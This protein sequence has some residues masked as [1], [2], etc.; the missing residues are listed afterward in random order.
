MTLPQLTT[1]QIERIV[2]VLGDTKKGFTG[3]EIGDYLTQC[4][5]DDPTPDMTKW[6]RLYNAFNAEANRS[7]S[8]NVV[9]KFIKCCMEPAQGLNDVERYKWIL[10]ELNKVLMLVGIELR[11]DGCFYAVSKAQGIGEVH[12]RTKKL[13]ERLADYSAHPVVLKCCREELL[14][15]DYF[16]AV[17]EAAKSLCNRVRAMSG[18]SDDGV[19]LF[20][21]A[22]NIKKPYIVYNSLQT[23][24]EQNQQNGLKEMLCGVIR[25][26]RNVT[27]HELRIHWDVNEQDA[28][29]ILIQISYLHKLLDA[30]KVIRKV[31]SQN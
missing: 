7:G 24:S 14:A 28:L 5:I 10:L 21:A 4:H 2:H 25:M 26:V 27:A 29:D 15:H 8:T 1:N 20:E 13:R 30:C 11:D 3:F 18:L 9:F 23:T 31:T 16:H 12:E 6:G 19:N 22:F 17:Q